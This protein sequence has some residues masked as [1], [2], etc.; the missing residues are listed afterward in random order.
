[1]CSKLTNLNVSSLAS[2][3]GDEA[4]TPLFWGAAGKPFCCF[5]PKDLPRSGRNGGFEG[6]ISSLA[7]GAVV[8]PWHGRVSCVPVVAGSQEGVIQHRVALPSIVTKYCRDLP[9]CWKG[10]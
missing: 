2:S 5:T 8:V 9:L 10:L 3:H 6:K 4:A 7:S 1:M